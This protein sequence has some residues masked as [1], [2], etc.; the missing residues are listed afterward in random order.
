MKL[1]FSLLFVMLAF[2]LFGSVDSIPEFYDRELGMDASFVNN[3][4]PSDLR[5]GLTNTYFFSYR[6]YKSAEK[7]KRM[8]LSFNLEGNITRQKDEGQTNDFNLDLNYR[9]GWGKRRKLY[10]KF[11]W[12]FGNDLLINPDFSSR[13]VE[14]NRI[15]NGF[16]EESVSNI[17][18]YRFDVGTGWFLGFQ[19]QI[20]QRFSV[21]T[22]SNLLFWIRYQKNINKNDVRTEL[23][24]NTSIYSINRTFALPNDITFFYR[25]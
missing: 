7:F 3:F 20:N 23:N 1:N 4:L 21:Y 16:L 8:N 13:N 22:E 15:V 6:K 2:S 24:S 10:K 9:I 18:S 11:D 5:L 14:I 25:F 19:Y 17:S 12:L